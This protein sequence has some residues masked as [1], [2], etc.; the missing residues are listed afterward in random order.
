MIEHG[1]PPAPDRRL[2]LLPRAEGE[3]AD[4]AAWYGEQAPGLASEFV[5]AIDAVLQRIAAEPVSYALICPRIR[6]ALVRGFRTGCSIPSTRI[7]S[8]CSPSSMLAD[9]RVAGRRGRHVD[10]SMKT[11][12]RL[13]PHPAA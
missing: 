3:I 11:A 2:V 4:G 10:G 1:E 6:R 9:T 5:R 7:G 8:R 12:A 13:P